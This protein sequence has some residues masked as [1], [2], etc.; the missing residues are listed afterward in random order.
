MSEALGLGRVEGGGAAV[1]RSVGANPIEKMSKAS[2]RLR[3]KGPGSSWYGEAAFT[4]AAGERK[5]LRRRPAGGSYPKWLGAR[6]GWKLSPAEKKR[7]RGV[8]FPLGSR[9]SPP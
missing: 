9:R 6:G 5:V 1:K 3:P 7:A 2:F 8:T 4:G